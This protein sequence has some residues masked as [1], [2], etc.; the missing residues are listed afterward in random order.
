MHWKVGVI[1]YSLNVDINN[2]FLVII[3]TNSDKDTLY[4]FS[5]AIDYKGIAA[6]GPGPAAQPTTQPSADTDEVAQ[7]TTR[8]TKQPSA[9]TDGMPSEVEREA[10]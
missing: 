3:I 4:K 6:L 5:D 7:S 10:S 8:P 9:D 2:R 1:S